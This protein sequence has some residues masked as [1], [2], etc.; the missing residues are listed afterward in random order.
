MPSGAK[1]R[2]AARKK[3]EQ[4]N[5]INPSTS[6]PQ[7]DDELKSLD[8]KGSDGGESG[9][10]AHHEHGDHDH[11][12]ND[13]S[14]EVEE[15]DLSAAQQFATEANSVE[16]V[17]DDVKIDEVLVEKEDS[18][19]V[20]ERDLQS[21]EISE[22]RNE[23][24]EHGETAKES[25]Y[26]EDQKNGVTSN[27]ESLAEENSKDDDNH[28]FEEEIACHE[29]VKSSD[30]SQPSELISTTESALI[31]EPGESAA[32]YSDNSLKA[33]DSVPEVENGDAGSR[34][35]SL[36]KSVV[37]PVEVT[38]LAMK[39]NEDNAYPLTDEKNAATSSLEESIPMEHDSKVLTPSS[40]SPSTEFTN[41][42][43]HIQNSQTPEFSENQPRVTSAPNMVQ[44][45]SWLS[46]CGLF[47]VLS[48]SN[49]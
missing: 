10:P 1:K 35:V 32:E 8:E 5:N 19:V 7:G 22:R 41:G 48:G 42:T 23:S 18:V 13:G 15:V 12:F 21:E 30:S 29:L 14:E 40:A 24:F 2:K 26:Y 3:K 20:I 31:E 45:T 17:S 38:N 46:C 39:E 27:G 6:N 34:S 49:R 47:E 25:P 43:K 36:E 16:E 9:S 28:S 4:Q 44:K 37:P 11:P 33:A